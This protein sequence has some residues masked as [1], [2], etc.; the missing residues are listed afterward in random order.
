LFDSFNFVFFITLGVRIMLLFFRR[1]GVA[2]LASLAFCSFSQGQVLFELA[3]DELYAEVGFTYDSFGGGGFVIENDYFSLDVES[4][5]GAGVNTN[6]D[7]MFPNFT[8][9]EAFLEVEVRPGANNAAPNFAVTLADEDG[10][11]ANGGRIV[12][13]YQYLV[14]LEGLPTD[15]FSIVEIDLNDFVFNQTS[16]QSEPGDDGAINYGLFQVQVQSR[17]G[18]TFRTDVDIRRVSLVTGQASGGDD[19]LGDFND[20]GVVDLAD[21]D[22]YNGNIGQP[23]SFNPELDL[24]ESGTIDAADLTQHVET[25]VQ[26]SNGVTGTA[27]GDINLD[28]VVNVLGDA[29]TLVGN[30]GNSVS[31]W[32]SGDLNGDQNVTVLGDAFA[33]V[34]NLGADNN[35]P[36]GAPAAS[37]VPEPGSG[38]VLF[39][40]ALIAG[41]RRRR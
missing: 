17:F 6:F 30:L 39:A 22:F 2:L 35:P 4:F 1:T 36:A 21:L 24:D 29:F 38:S 23:A 11:A 18:E 31:S 15:T 32:S 20:D 3:P 12:E 14:D 25:L 7:E 13:D 37:A 19:V 10:F 34:G 26:T 16:F 8:N 9:S 40:L 5:G 33:L 41:A 28:G 27:V